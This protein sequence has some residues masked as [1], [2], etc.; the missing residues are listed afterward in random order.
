MKRAITNTR[1][2]TNTLIEESIFSHCTNSDHGAAI[3]SKSLNSVIS[4]CTGTFCETESHHGQFFY[5]TTVERN[6]VYYTEIISCGNS[7]SYYSSVLYDGRLV[8]KYNNFSYNKCLRQCGH[9]MHLNTVNSSISIYLNIIKNEAEGIINNFQT[10]FHLI[11]YTNTVQNTI[12]KSNQCL[13]YLDANSTALLISCVM[14]DNIL[15]SGV[16]VACS[17]QSN[18]IT[19]DGC[20]IDSYE[21]TE[22]VTFNNLI[23]NVIKFNLIPDSLSYNKRFLDCQTYSVIYFQFHFS[24]F[25]VCIDLT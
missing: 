10:L 16:F 2:L 15:N 23:D 20:Y 21:E 6:E 3:L 14:K 18:S 13:V 5:Q 17:N 11:K 4:K 22:R 25:F 19:F 1:Q 8:N 7:N 24:L 12:T 9:H